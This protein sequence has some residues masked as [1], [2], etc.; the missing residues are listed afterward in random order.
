LPFRDDASRWRDIL[1]SLVLIEQFTAGMHFNAYRQDDKTK[2]AVE[3]QLLIL[4]EAAK[5]LGSLAEERCPRHDWKGLR[6]MGDILR[7]AYH[8]V[9]DRLIWN[10]VT[11]ELPPL[12]LC[13][14]TVVD[15]QDLRIS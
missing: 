13:V 4:S 10:T 9:D 8:R 14:E 1:E 3:R 11:T 12:R 15:D 5:L 2:S 7:H 6:G